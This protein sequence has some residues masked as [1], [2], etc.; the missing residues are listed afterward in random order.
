MTDQRVLTDAEITT[1]ACE[2]LPRWDDTPGQQARVIVPHPFARAVEAAVLA[3]CVELH[4]VS[5]GRWGIKAH[6]GKPCV[7]ESEARTRERAA[8]LRGF[9]GQFNDEAYAREMREK[10][11]MYE[12]AMLFTDRRFPP[13]T[14]EP[15]VGPSGTKYRM[16]NDPLCPPGA[17]VS[18]LGPGESIWARARSVLV[19]DAPAVAALMA[20][21]G[22]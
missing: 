13:L 17:V 2:Q 20:E 5:E 18:R 3:K 4:G 7:P 19:E 11:G 14:P 16:T 10:Q 1:L 15:V 9:Y 22:K 8:H 12:A 6:G 21:Q